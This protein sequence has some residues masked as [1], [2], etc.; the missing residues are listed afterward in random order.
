MVAARSGRLKAGRATGNRSEGPA[1]CILSIRLLPIHGAGLILGD[2][3][4]DTP[5]ALNVV[6]FAS[7]CSTFFS[8]LFISARN[9]SR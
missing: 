9:F 1:S 6:I 3:V 5:S 4:H 8:R 7:N 2:L